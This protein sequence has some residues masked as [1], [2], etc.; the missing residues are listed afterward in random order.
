MDRV[1]LVL[2]SIKEF[3]IEKGRESEWKLLLFLS[4]A[5]LIENWEAA[6]TVIAYFL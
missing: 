1:L 2:L 4:Q 3:I 6:D 5:E